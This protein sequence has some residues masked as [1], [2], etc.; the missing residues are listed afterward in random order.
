MQ[1]S[2]CFAQQKNLQ[3]VLKTSSRIL[4]AREARQ[5]DLDAALQ[6]GG[7]MGGDGDGKSALHV[8]ARSGFCEGLLKLLQAGFDPNLR[9]KLPG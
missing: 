4:E 6:Q 1:D 2:G 3:R 7:G 9:D 5:A 8:A